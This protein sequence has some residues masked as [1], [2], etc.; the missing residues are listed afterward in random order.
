MDVITK[1]YL[2]YKLSLTRMI[3]RSVDNPPDVEDILQ[4][5]YL[6]TYAANKQTEVRSIQAYLH[7]T[8]R[9]LALNF[10]THSSVKRTDYKADMDQ[11]EVDPF[12]GGE[13]E[14]RSIELERF[15][16]FCRAVRTLPPQQRRVFVLK[17]VY[18]YSLKEIAQDLGVSQKAVEKHISAGLLTVRDYMKRIEA[19][20]PVERLPKNVTAG[21]GYKHE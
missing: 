20:A 14:Q 12:D 8:A 13:P 21:S 3:R 7:T 10:A 17:K 11:H 15:A 2:K 16:H 9:N 5:T 19:L 18:G 4:E 6:R 1:N